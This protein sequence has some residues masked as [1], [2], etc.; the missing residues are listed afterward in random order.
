MDDK[1]W[2]EEMKPYQYTYASYAMY[3]AEGA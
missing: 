2:T 1:G 3:A